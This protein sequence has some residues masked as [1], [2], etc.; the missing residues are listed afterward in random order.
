MT[1]HSLRFV[2][3]ANAIVSASL[4][5][6]SMS[7]KA[8]Y[9]A[10]DSGLLLLSDVALREIRDVLGREKFDRYVSKDK[11][12][13]FLRVLVRDAEW[14]ETRTVIRACRDPDDD[15]YLEL[16][17]DGS[18]D[19]VVSGDKDLLVLGPFRGIPILRPDQFLEWLPQHRA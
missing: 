5:E 1:K 18:T 16:A 7:A 17:V 11:R 15:K 8:F 12:R 9:L 13:R 10:V 19:C 2:F 14:V 3:D 4:S 6:A